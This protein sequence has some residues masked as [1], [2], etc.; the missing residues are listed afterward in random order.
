MG[1]TGVG[2]LGAAML[3][4]AVWGHPSYGYFALLKV[5]VALGSVFLA[6]R[7]WRIGSFTAPLGLALLTTAF[8]HA[9]FKMRRAQWFSVDVI[10]GIIFLIAATLAFANWRRPDGASPK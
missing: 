10:T 3:A 4:Y 7:L 9:F 8:V 6:F 2:L 5:Y 1:A